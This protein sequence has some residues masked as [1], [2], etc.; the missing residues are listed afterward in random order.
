MGP[1]SRSAWPGRQ[2]EFL[3]HYFMLLRDL[4]MRVL[5]DA[6]TDFVFSV[7]GSTYAIVAALVLIAGIAL[8]IWFR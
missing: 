1:G 2:R 7:H 4:A 5:P 6:Q 8:W 3:L